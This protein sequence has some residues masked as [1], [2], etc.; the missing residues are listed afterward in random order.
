MKLLRKT[1][2]VFFILA[3]LSILLLAFLNRGSEKVV[4]AFFTAMA[5]VLLA[6]VYSKDRPPEAA[7]RKKI[8]FWLKSEKIATAL[9]FALLTLILAVFV[10]VDHQDVKTTFPALLCYQLKDRSYVQ[11]SSYHDVPYG[12]GFDVEQLKKVRPDLFKEADNRKFDESGILLYHQ[13]L[14][15]ELLRSLA[16]DYQNS[17]SPEI[18]DLGEV[19]VARLGD[20]V[21]SRIYSADEIEGL[22]K[23]NPFGVVKVGIPIRIALP[24]ATRMKITVPSYFKETEPQVGEIVLE[25]PFFFR[26]SIKTERISGV[27]GAGF[28]RWLIPFSDAVSISGLPGARTW[29]NIANGRTI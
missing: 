16:W 20:R 25:K 3:L 11:L 13:L 23:D 8:A 18:L 19:Q 17:W 24:P 7:L 1:V 29:R 26:V 14:Q 10:F 12:Y 9:V 6:M 15:K 21:D 27:R 22:M 28:Y 2:P 5:A 4:T